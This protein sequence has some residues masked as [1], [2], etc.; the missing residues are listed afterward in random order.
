M[1][2]WVLRKGIL[3]LWKTSSCIAREV[4]KVSFS[5]T[6]TFYDSDGKD[7]IVMRIHETAR[8]HGRKEVWDELGDLFCVWPYLV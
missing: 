3:I 4:V 2:H 8:I 5:L 6:I 1:L 7:F